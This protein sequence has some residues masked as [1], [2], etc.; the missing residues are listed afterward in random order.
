MI[1]MRIDGVD[2]ILQR[3]DTMRKD[4][5][6]RQKLI[7]EKLAQFGIDTAGVKFQSA[8]YDGTNDVHMEPPQ[9]VNSNTVRVV[10]SGRAVAFIEFGTGINY[11][12]DHPKAAE[13]G[14]IRGSYGYGLGKLDAWMYDGEPGTNG[15]VI[16]GGANEGKVLTFGNPANRCMYDTAKAMRDKILDIVKEV[17]GS[18]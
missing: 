15:Y 7:L 6:R 8:Q 3:V 16:P 18:G 4:L 9:W 13:F 1:R 10:A 5:P 14:A 12:D 17:Y 2:A 11:R